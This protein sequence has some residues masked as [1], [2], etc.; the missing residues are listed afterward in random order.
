[1]LE[2]IPDVAQ[3]DGYSV[4]ESYFRL[5]SKVERLMRER[6]GDSAGP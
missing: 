3:A 1:M 5:S 4:V 2:Q 6:D